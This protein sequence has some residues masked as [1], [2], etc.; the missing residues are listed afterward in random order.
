MNTRQAEKAIKE[1]LRDFHV[2]NDEL[3]KS[4]AQGVITMLYTTDFLENDLVKAFIEFCKTGI[5][6]MTKVNH[7]SNLQAVTQHTSK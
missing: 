5:L 7:A 3:H 6:D 4:V 2:V 1:V